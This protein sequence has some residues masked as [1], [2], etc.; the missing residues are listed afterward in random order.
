LIVGR[1]LSEGTVFASHPGWAGAL[2]SIDAHFAD[3]RRRPA[4]DQNV[5]F[6]PFGLV[7]DRPAWVP[8]VPG[9]EIAAGSAGRV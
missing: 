4:I 2:V 1:G 7:T 5:H 8:F 3:G 9:E 6:E